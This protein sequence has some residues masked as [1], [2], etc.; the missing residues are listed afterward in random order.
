MSKVIKFYLNASKWLPTEQQWTYLSSCISRIDCEYVHNF[1][2]K[3]D[4]KIRLLSQLLIRYSIKLLT[5]M[6]WNDI[7]IDRSPNGKPFYVNKEAN[8]SKLD[9]NISHSNDYVV[10]CA[11]RSFDIDYRIGVDVMKIEEDDLVK[12]YE[13]SNRI[14]R[15]VFTQQEK[16]FVDSKPD[17]KD[18]IK[19]FNRL[20][21][22]KESYVK[23][24]GT[25]IR[26]ELNT[27]EFLIQNDFI[28]KNSEIINNTELQVDSKKRIDCKFYEQ[29]LDD[30]YL[31]SICLV[32]ENT[33]NELN[34][35]IYLKSQVFKELEV[36]EL[37]KT[38]TQSNDSNNCNYWSKYEKKD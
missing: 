25:G 35:N 9:F 14:M 36:D 1:K 22:L 26:V 10:I 30:L 34:E 23:A 8:K 16:G 11:I 19:A 20:W 29:I 24:I 4:C 7:N 27:I 33:S 18:K 6:S 32:S 12:Q 21:A 38:A 17:I 2:F 5:N 3:K 31:T 15:K 13:Q 37:I 28:S